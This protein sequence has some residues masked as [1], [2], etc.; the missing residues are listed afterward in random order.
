MVFFLS[1]LHT[2]PLSLLAIVPAWL[3]ITYGTAR[4]MYRRSSTARGRE[5]LALAHR[6]EAV[7]RELV[8][9]PPPEP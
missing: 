2:G 6:L 8:S 9:S 7:V 4:T 1:G 3:G 5:L